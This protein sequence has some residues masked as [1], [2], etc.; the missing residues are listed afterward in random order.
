MINTRAPD[1]A[2]K[3]KYELSS[4]KNSAQNK[5]ITLNKYRAHVVWF[6]LCSTDCSSTVG[7]REALMDEGS[8][9]HPLPLN[10]TTK[11]NLSWWSTRNCKTRSWYTLNQLPTYIVDDWDTKFEISR[12]VASL[13]NNS[14]QFL[15]WLY[16]NWSMELSDIQIIWL[17]HAP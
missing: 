8:P 12:C 5:M 15:S 13:S 6:L 1:G 7:K 2:N 16:H 17:K 9:R 11:A 3:W 14:V 10:P 4:I